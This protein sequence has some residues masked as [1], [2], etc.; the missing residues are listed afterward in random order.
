MAFGFQSGFKLTLCQLLA[1]PSTRIACSPFLSLLLFSLFSK[2]ELLAAG[3]DRSHGLV[4]LSTL[5]VNSH[6]TDARVFSPFSFLEVILGGTVVKH[7]RLGKFL[8][9]RNIR[10]MVLKLR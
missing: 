3:G 2:S 7:K 6:L 10:A 1:I 5:G 4:I 9:L 8:D